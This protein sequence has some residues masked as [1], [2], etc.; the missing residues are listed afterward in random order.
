MS[1]IAASRSV[2]Q[3]SGAGPSARADRFPGFLILAGARCRHAAARAAAGALRLAGALVVVLMASLAQ[4]QPADPGAARTRMEALRSEIQLV[5]TALGSRELRDPELQRMRQRVDPML[6]ELRVLTDQLS[7]R[8]EQAKLRL[9][10]LGPKPDAKAP[11]ESGDIAA[12]RALREKAQTEADEGARLSRAVL[13][14]AEHI[15]ANVADQRRALFARTLFESSPSFVSPALWGPLLSTLPADVRAMNLLASDW[16]ATALM[17]M[18]ERSFGLVLLSLLAGFALYSAR[19]RYLP[20]IMGRLETGAEA[21]R[22]KRLLAALVRLVAGALPAAL[23]SWLVYS[24]L[25]NG[26]LVPRRVEPFVWALLGGFAFLAFVSAL[27]DAT[28]APKWPHRRIFGVADR[29]ARILKRLMGSA[30]AVLVTS[31]AVEALLGAIAAG[32]SLSIA[33]RSVFALLFAGVLAYWLNKLRDTHDEDEACL[34]PY[35]LVDG[36]KLAPLRL[37]GWLLVV[38]I[39]GA[40]LAGYAAF[41]SFLV[42]QSAWV[43]IVATLVALALMF[44]DEALQRLLAGNGRVSLTLQANVGLRRRSLE[45]AAVLGTGLVKLVLLFLAGMLILAPWGIESADLTSSIKAAFFGFKVGDVTVSLSAII[46]AALLFAL[47]L[48][49][50]KA[51]TRWLDERFLPAT[52]L[53]TGLRNSMRTMVRYVGFLAALA[54]AISSLGLSLERLTIV[55]GALSVGIGFGLQSVVSNFVSGLILLWERPIRVGDQIVVGDGEGIVKRINVRST[56]IETFDRSTVIVPNSN[57][58]SGVVKN[59]VRS[60]RTGR[61]LIALAVARTARPDH[62]REVMLTAA[63]AHPQVMAEPSPRVMFK[64]I[65]ETSLEFELFCVVPDVDMVGVVASDLHFAIFPELAQHGIGQPE[66][67]V[68][69]KGLDRI[70]DTLDEL[71]DTIEDAQEAQAAAYQARRR[72]APPP[73]PAAPATEAPRPA[74]KKGS[75]P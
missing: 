41:A 44:A 13:L 51:L 47:G 5:E 29:N 42:E 48:A 43:V 70:E 23:A 6:D 31:K 75:R 33:A 56:E 11:P 3:A 61:V 12:E 30:A 26:G 64:K 28:L 17:R 4:A 59:R 69:V 14:Q 34:G 58:I 8:A 73:P 63:L 32:L 65:G 39:G 54:L 74:A 36:A 55:A 27:S 37:V 9:D 52:D 71:V 2:A 38:L 20:S 40:A 68:A 10:Q 67:E 1:M 15:I 22:M 19:L 57:L 62:V 7:Q 25:V 24:A 16:L 45:Q 72:P 35:M 46:I 53:D 60:D 18:Q 21:T 66:R 50:T 49:A